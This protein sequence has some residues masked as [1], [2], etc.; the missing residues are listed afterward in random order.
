MNE[1][2]AAATVLLT[3]TAGLLAYMLTNLRDQ[4]DEAL[5]DLAIARGDIKSLTGRVTTLRGDNITLTSQVDTLRVGHD[6]LVGERDAAVRELGR[7][8][9]EQI[10]A[11]PKRGANGKFVAKPKPA[12]VTPIGAKSCPPKTAK[13]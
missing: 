3:L 6:K 2:L 13:A 5:Q 9:A 1:L 7:L 8:K 11:K 4:R 12:T 10:A